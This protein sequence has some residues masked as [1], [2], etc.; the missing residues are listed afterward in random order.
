MTIFNKI[1]AFFTALAVAV[2]GIACLFKPKIP[3]AVSTDELMNMDGDNRVYPVTLYVKVS[4]GAKTDNITGRAEI[5]I[6]SFLE[7]Y[8][9]QYEVFKSNNGNPDCRFKRNLSDRTFTGCI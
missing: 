4:S 9:A 7:C 1:V 5:D 2:G 3:K 8:E 6:N